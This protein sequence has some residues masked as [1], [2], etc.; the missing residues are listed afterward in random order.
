MWA[1]F[2]FFSA[3]F[4]ALTSILAKIGIA[5]VN[6]NLA[7]AIRTVVVVLMAWGIV[8]LTKGQIGLANISKKNWIFLIL[9]GLATGASWLCYYRALQEG[10]ASKVAPIDKLSV[11]LTLILAFI[12]LHEDFTMKSLIGT[13]LI[14]I[15]TLIMV[16]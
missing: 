5:G 12:F 14:T 13:I 9:S 16:L 4:A 11:V 3:L 15:G 6:S 1:I 2:A 7:T 10:E 8:F